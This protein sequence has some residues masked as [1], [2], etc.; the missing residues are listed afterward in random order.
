MARR[1]ISF[2]LPLMLCCQAVIA[3]D[4]PIQKNEIKLYVSPANVEQATLALKLDYQKAENQTVCFFD[5]NDESLA[6]HHLI[7]RAR[8]PA[9]RSGDSSVKIRMVAGTSELSK[10]EQAIQ[11]EQDWTHEADPMISRSL[12]RNSI[13]KGLLAK[14]VAAE[15]SVSELFNEAQQQLV[16][17]RMKDFNWQ[18]LNRYGPIQV[19]VWKKHCKFEGFDEAVTV[20]LWH[21]EIAGKKE[22]ILEVSTKAMAASDAHSHALASQFYAAA[23]AAGLGEPSKI[24]KTN[25]VFDFYRSSR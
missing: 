11:P 18:T 6:A 15:K 13:T 21:L 23:K 8:Q 7:L 2:V 12:N 3:N 17:A 24:S 25:K 19:Q 10:I 4:V 9:D 1:L 14:V 22:E 20:E 5:T 16:T